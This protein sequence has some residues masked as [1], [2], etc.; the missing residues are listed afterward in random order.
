MTE[1]N[2][3]WRGNRHLHLMV[4][5]SDREPRILGVSLLEGPAVQRRTLSGA[6]AVRVE[7]NG[8][9]MLIDAFDD[10]RITRGISRPE[11]RGHSFLSHERGT[12][13]VDV[14]LGADPLAAV[15]IHFADLSLVRSRA[16][17][18]AVIARYFDV[19]TRGM[20]RRGA[21]TLEHL[22][23]HPDWKRIG[24]LVGV[25]PRP[26][27]GFE[28]YRDRRGHFRWR[29]RRP[30]GDIVADSGQGYPARE[31]CEADLRWIRS[32][33]FRAE[34]RSLDITQSGERP[35]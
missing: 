15:E 31:A 6:L 1:S 22:I 23:Q 34:V 33:G 32:E 5:F 10:P 26:L 12:V 13:F 28:I 27:E 19:R 8:K 30:D 21:L 20:R 14:P 29:L 3:A 4:E 35:N 18:P 2:A 25:A 7:V 24:P 16:I 17:E 11:A 9:S